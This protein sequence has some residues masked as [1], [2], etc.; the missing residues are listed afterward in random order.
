MMRIVKVDRRGHRAWYVALAPCVQAQTKYPSKPIQVQVVFPAG[1]PSDT[2]ARIMCKHAEKVLGQRVDHSERGRAP[3]AWRAGTTCAVPRRTGTGSPATTSRTS[4][5]SRLVVKEANFAREDFIP[6]IH[7]AN[8][9][10][11]F[12]VRADSPYK[13]I[14][15]LIA[16]AK[17][18]PDT[19]TL[20]MAGRFLGHH[21]AVLQL[22]DAAKYPD[23]GHTFSRLGRVDSRDAGRAD[24]GSFGQPVG[25]AAARGQGA[26]TGH[27]HRQAPPHGTQCA[28]LCRE[29][30]PSGGDEHRPRDS[31]P[32][33]RVPGDRQDPHAMLSGKPPDAG[34]SWKT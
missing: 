7:W 8:D 12:A 30:L 34:I 9:P 2:E 33:G 11:V 23:Q 22:E 29:G 28:D 14:A 27:R 3:A 24:E 20:G 19:V 13:S 10:T 26:H 4:S 6:I 16:E 21:L 5:P 32:Q 1:G 25:Y 31:R 15:D 18:K 17:A